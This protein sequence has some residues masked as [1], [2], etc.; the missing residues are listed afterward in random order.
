[1]ERVLL[2]IA[3]SS[4]AAS[5][6]GGCQADLFAASTLA[7]CGCCLVVIEESD[8]VQGRLF[9]KGEGEL[10]SETTKPLRAVKTWW[11]M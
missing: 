4:C 6:V 1:M 5:P 2:T 7:Y 11:P 9:E 3:L 10:M 8:G